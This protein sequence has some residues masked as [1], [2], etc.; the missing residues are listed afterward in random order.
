[1]RRNINKNLEKHQKS[2]L[3]LVSIDIAGP[4]IKSIR[5][6]EYFLQIIDSFTR[7][8]WTIPLRAKNDAI[9]ALKTWKLQ[10]ELK[11]GKKVISR[12]SDDEPELKKVMEGW[13][14]YDGVTAQYTT[15]ASSHQNGSV[16]RAIQT[17]ENAIRT[18]THAAGCPAEFW[19][20]AAKTD[21]YLRNRLAHR[22]LVEGKRT[23]PQE[24]YTGF[25]QISNQIRVW[26]CVCYTHVDPKTLPIKQLHNKQANRGRE[27]IFLGYCKNTD[28]QY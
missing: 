16:E 2:S 21:A 8:I 1:M 9:E 4:F 7:K 19:C 10:G 13:Q 11:T 22:P 25:K 3:A 20:F 18:M 5:G 12:R 26:G 23:S 6:F 15:I 17:T 24:A 28:K 14:K 27:A